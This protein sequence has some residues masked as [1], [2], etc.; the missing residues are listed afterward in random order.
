VI[1][2]FK[3]LW[4][5]ITNFLF[6]DQYF[7]WQTIIYL[8]LFSWAMSWTARLAGTTPA[9]EFILASG[10]WL[11]WM[12]GIAWGLEANNIR[13]LGI[14]IAPWVA[15]AILCTYLFG[16]FPGGNIS[17]ALVIW[18]LLSV[19]LVAVPAFVNWEFKPKVPMPIVRQQLIL[20]LLLAVLF[21]SWF[22]FYFR[23]QS[24]F[25]EY[26]SLLSDNFSN[27]G[28]V[29]RLS[30]EAG[31]AGGVPLLTAV[32]EQVK[33]ELQGMP[34]PWVERWLLNLEGQM[35]KI[36]QNTQDAM[37]ASAEAGLWQLQARP[38]SLNDGGYALEILALWRGP[39]STPESYYLEKVC[40]IRP[41]VP[42]QPVTRA[43]EGETAPDVPDPTP[44]AQVSCDLETPKRLGKPEPVTG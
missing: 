15:G 5:R 20:L 28:F 1:N 23:L 7:A 29:T 18:P 34:W 27:S 22:Q 11:F 35:Q 8:A 17:T 16:L 30:Q 39:A 26:P 42:R 36:R 37:A 32:E 33:N 12:L 14:P 21:S 10:S 9:T 40:L 41:Q 31:R 2:F 43:T 6:P 25:R 3:A 13:P 19:G 24:W 4:E 44:L 38:R